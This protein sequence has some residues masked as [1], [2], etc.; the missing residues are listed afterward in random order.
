MADV[1]G[2]VLECGGGDECGALM[3]DDGRV[4]ALFQAFGQALRESAANVTLAEFVRADVEAL[5]VDRML[6]AGAAQ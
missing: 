6:A 1:A 3:A 2:A 4:D 5:L